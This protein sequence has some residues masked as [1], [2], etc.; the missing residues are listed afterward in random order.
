MRGST[1]WTTSDD[2]VIESHLASKTTHS[3]AIKSARAA[4]QPLLCSGYLPQ[5]GSQKWSILSPPDI[6]D[7]SALWPKASKPIHLRNLILV[8]AASAVGRQVAS[9]VLVAGRLHVHHH[10]D[11]IRHVHMQARRA[12]AERLLAP[13]AK[14]SIRGVHL[15]PEVGRQHVSRELGRQVQLPVASSELRLQAAHQIER[16]APFDLM[17]ATTTTARPGAMYED[18]RTARGRARK[19]AWHRS[20]CGNACMRSAKWRGRTSAKSD[21]GGQS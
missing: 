14:R 8:C 7:C 3:T 12:E 17:A 4:T 16:D 10:I 20:T 6:P 2:P 21:F 15:R 18:A 5:E 1:A 13:V 11:R 19:C 9:R